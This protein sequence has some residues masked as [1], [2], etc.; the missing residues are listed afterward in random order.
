MQPPIGGSVRSTTLKAGPENAKAARDFVRSCL[1]S[2]FGFDTDVIV[3]LASELATNAILHSRLTFEVSVEVTATC[4][5]VSVDDLSA[6]LPVPR[7]A[8][9]T[10]TSGRGL[11][12]VR[13]AADRWGI[14][15][16]PHGK[17]P[18]FKVCK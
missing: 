17:S 6:I 16:T 8:A 4:I 18:W 13:A 15:P 5:E 7:Q 11:A 14:E 10:E 1:T 12:I 9:D 3:L 2:T